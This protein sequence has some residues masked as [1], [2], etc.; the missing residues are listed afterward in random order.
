MFRITEFPDCCGA[1]SISDFPLR[2]LKDTEI[3]FS[4]IL[5]D[6]VEHYRYSLIIVILDKEQRVFWHQCLRRKGFKVT[7]VFTNKKTKHKLTTY[8]LVVKP[9]KKTT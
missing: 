9:L 8:M 6:S 1:C 2:K 4:K 3:I 5:K 7:R